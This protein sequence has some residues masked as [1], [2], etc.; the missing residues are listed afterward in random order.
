MKR[1]VVPPGWGAPI[2]AAGGVSLCCGVL[3]LLKISFTGR[4][5]ALGLVWNLFLA[6]LPLV[7][8][9]AA[10]GASARGA[11][12]GGWLAVCS[13]AWLLS[14]P[15]APYIVTDLVHLNPAAHS[16]FWLNLVLTSLCALTGLVVGF[17]S[18]F[19]MHGLVQRR[20]GATV[21][22][23]FVVGAA[24]LGGFGM[25]LGRF[26]RWNSWDLLMNPTRL[27]GDVGYWARNVSADSR[28]AVIPALF[29]GFVLLSY[30]LLYAL[31]GLRTGRPGVAGPAR[32]EL[33]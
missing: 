15:N 33:P 4:W 31:T 24:A 12:Q 16:T 20:V 25:Y 26:Y 8:A 18:L 10:Q 17:L 11:A 3:V 13:A 27:A 28:S 23:A 32:P 7:F 22:W 14:F 19:L 5:S 6:W 21:G 9:L 2:T 30:L 29:A 1:L